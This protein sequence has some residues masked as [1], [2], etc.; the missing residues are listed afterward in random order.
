MTFRIAD[1]AF[2]WAS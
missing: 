2:R 1:R